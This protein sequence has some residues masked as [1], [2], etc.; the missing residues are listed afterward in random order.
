[1]LGAE[2]LLDNGPRGHESGDVGDGV[3]SVDGG[4]ADDGT[5]QVEGR[6]DGRLED[7]VNVRGGR[8]HNPGG[9]L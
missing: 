6:A 4:E 8:G 7:P 3:L 2:D 5:G 9:Q 1:M